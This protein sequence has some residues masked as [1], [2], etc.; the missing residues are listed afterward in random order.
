MSTPVSFNGST[1][2]IPVQGDI[3]WGPNATRIW[4]AL[5]TYALAPVGGLFTLTADVN[6]GP[7]FGLLSAY[8]SGRGTVA[9]SGLVR[10]SKT[11][12]IDWKN[13][14][15]S[16]NNVLATDSSDNLTW[17]GVVIPVG[18]S[19]LLDGQIWIGNSSNLPIGRTLT[20]DVTVTDTGVT[21]IGSGKIV[22]SQINAA[23]AIDYSKLSL[24]G[25]IINTDINSAAAIAYTKLFLTNQ[26]VNADVNAS[27]AIA[28]SKLNLVG[29]VSLATDVTGNLATSHLNSGSSAS[30]STFWR[31]DGTWATPAG[32][33]V[34]SLTGTT[35]QINVSASTGAVTISTPQSIGTTSSP[36]FAS[37]TLTAVTNQLTL[38]TTNTTTLSATAP[39]AS[40]TYTIPDA[41]ADA[42]FL[43]TKGSQT[44]TGVLTFTNVLQIDQTGTAAHFL[45]GNSVY[46]DSPTSSK[47][48][49]VIQGA[50]SV[51]NTN[52]L[53]KNASQAAA[54]TYTIPDAGTDA[55]FVMTAGSQTI[56]GTKTFSST[57]A[58]SVSGNAATVTTNANLT[59][60]IT[61][62]G[63][64]TSIASQT[65]TGTKFVVDTT[66]TLV[67]PVLGVASA[68]SINFGG[69]ALSVYAEGSW[70]PSDQSG[71]SL[72]FS[73]TTAKYVK[74]G[75]VVYIECFITFPA[76]GN[77]ASN[78]IGTLPFS[79]DDDGPTAAIKSSSG[80]TYVVKFLAGTTNF[81]VVLPTT[82]VAAINSALTNSQ[83]AFS[84][85]YFHA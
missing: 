66:P 67:T 73:T 12:T 64:A 10:M 85:F 75:K 83:I 11:D 53:I 32:T 65:G 29:S 16:G 24:T 77:G 80:T 35:N 60:V 27:A 4:V 8:F 28:Y 9:S 19:N 26:I 56:A 71:A 51:G 23:A 69:T 59:G 36:T 2:Q 50:D 18:T 62:S 33:G 72:T 54:R 14:G 20:G 31:G 25:S 22:N 42:N 61:S 74:I 49:L 68:T 5:G 21:S 82:G 57:I 45:Q 6:F 43:M 3:G 84:G 1:Y 34:T 63:N 38:G 76:T 78:Q 55:S 44:V 7:N 58:G 81:Q 46:F 41:G 17:N 48:A 37:E 13:N 70:T 40:R 79:V 52:T 30:S 47:G 15:G 39:S